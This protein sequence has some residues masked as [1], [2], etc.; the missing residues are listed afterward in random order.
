MS[1]IEILDPQFVRQFFNVKLEEGETL[2]FY[3]TKKSIHPILLGLQFWKVVL[4]VEIHLPI[5][6]N[7][8]T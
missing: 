4:P 1:E 7:V 6:S 3:G 8:S 5:D 2:H